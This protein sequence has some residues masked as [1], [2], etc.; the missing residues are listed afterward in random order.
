MSTAL[1]VRS[2]EA[3]SWHVI[4]SQAEVLLKTG[5]LSE[6]IKTAEQAAAIILTGRELG[7]G[8]M[9]AL[10]TINVIKGKPTVS[11]QL[12]LALINKTN[13]VVNML[14]EGDDKGATCIIHRK[15]RQPYTATFGPKEARAMGLDGKDN[16]KKQPA[17][18]YRWRAVAE[19]AR[20]TFP[21]VILGLYT[22]DEMG[23]EVEPESGEIAE[24]PVT[25]PVAVPTP[26]QQVETEEAMEVEPDDKPQTLIDPQAPLP[27][28]RV[29]AAHLKTLMNLIKKIEAHGMTEA[30]L[31]AEL[32]AHDE[33][34]DLQQEEVM[35]LIAACS[36]I[37]NTLV[38]KG[39]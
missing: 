30:E 5:F 3:H 38:K 11:P 17:T 39:R 27:S 2:N 7:V 14:I 1:E 26:G 8:P 24:M 18:M 12:M 22:P 36:A 29:S 37:L 31:R 23:A 6:A 9:A 4:R 15:G 16:Y 25:R 19:A 32:D 13:Q 28:G 10:N 35:D 34:S 21:D 20:M 33:W